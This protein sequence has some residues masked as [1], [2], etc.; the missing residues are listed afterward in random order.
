MRYNT[1]NASF[2]AQC[3]L[4][5][6]PM[7]WTNYKLFPITTMFTVRIHIYHEAW[8]TNELWN[9]GATDSF[10]LVFLGVEKGRKRRK[11]VEKRE[12]AVKF[13]KFLA[14]SSKKSVNLQF[15]RKFTT[16]SYFSTHFLGFLGPRKRRVKIR[17]G[18]PSCEIIL[19][20]LV[21]N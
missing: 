2:A 9:R 5:H 16:F 20:I 6:H 15:S 21:L 8:L 12:K 10:L 14:F 18:C 17:V 4:Y 13:S 7:S 11:R 19:Y 1:Y 3:Y